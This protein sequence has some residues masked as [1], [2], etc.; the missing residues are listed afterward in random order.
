[1]KVQDE[2]APA[3]DA[4][5]LYDHVSRWASKCHENL[6]GRVE[7]SLTITVFGGMA[8]WPFP[9]ETPFS[10]CRFDPFYYCTAARLPWRVVLLYHER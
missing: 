1:M 5:N 6:V 9:P 2:G 3:T 8:C 4:M 7:K 10:L